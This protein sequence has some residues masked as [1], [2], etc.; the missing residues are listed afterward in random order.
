VIDPTLL[1]TSPACVEVDTGTGLTRG[2][3]ICE[4]YTADE[5]GEPRAAGR[6]RYSSAGM[7]EMAVGLDVDGFRS[8]MMNRLARPMALPA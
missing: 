4:F 8:L 2:E 5:F 6:N 7:V 3:T 1:Q